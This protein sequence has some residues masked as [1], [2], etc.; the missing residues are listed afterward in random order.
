MS[1]GGGLLV[2]AVGEGEEVLQLPLQRLECW[3][4]HRV[5]QTINVRL[6][7]SLLTT[8]R[9]DIDKMKDDPSERGKLMLSKMLNELLNKYSEELSSM[10]GQRNLYRSLKHKNMYNLVPAL[11]HDV[12]EVRRTALGRLHPVPVLNLVQHLGVRHACECDEVKV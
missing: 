1:V 8:D 4:L 11:E 3:S 7:L 12:V 6:T 10:A 9:T 2:L 5:L